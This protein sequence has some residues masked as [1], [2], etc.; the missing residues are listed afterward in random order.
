MKPSK[1][2]TAPSLQLFPHTCV[3]EKMPWAEGGDW[4]GSGELVDIPGM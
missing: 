1:E 2:L 4:R 3:F